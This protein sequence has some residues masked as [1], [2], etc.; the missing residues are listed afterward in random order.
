MTLSMDSLESEKICGIKNAKF[1]IFVNPASYLV[2]IA[3]S[4][5]FLK[6]Y[7]FLFYNIAFLPFAKREIFP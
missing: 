2:V 6:F 3:F 4:G 5:H 7:D 1:G